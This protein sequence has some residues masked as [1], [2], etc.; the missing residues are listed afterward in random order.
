MI[1]EEIQTRRIVDH[2]ILKE[3]SDKLVDYLKSRKLDILSTVTL[4]RYGL[5][6]IEQGELIIAI[7]EL[8][9]E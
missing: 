5:D 3:E 4:L 7:K 9:K 8:E 2:T 1:D 6:E